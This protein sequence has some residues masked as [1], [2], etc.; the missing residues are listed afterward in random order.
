M[1]NASTL[2]ARFS[3]AG[4]TRI[5]FVRTLAL[6]EICV[7]HYCQCLMLGY[8]AQMVSHFAQLCSER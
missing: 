8:F 5:E 2:A 6:L 7:R 3:S 4:W 1:E